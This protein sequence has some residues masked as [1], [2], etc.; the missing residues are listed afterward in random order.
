MARGHIT[1]PTGR[2]HSRRAPSPP[3][4]RLQIGGGPYIRSVFLSRD[5]AGVRA[6]RAEPP[7]G[8]A[9]AAHRPDRVRSVRRRRAAIW[10]GFLRA[11]GSIGIV[12]VPKLSSRQVAAYGSRA[13]ARP[14]ALATARRGTCGQE[15]DL[16]G[17]FLSC[18]ESRA[19]P[20]SGSLCD[21]PDAAA[22]AASLALIWRRSGKTPQRQPVAP[23]RRPWRIYAP[24]R[25]ISAP[26]CAVDAS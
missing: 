15:A 25:R 4:R 10:R 18:R 2:I 20:A 6:L 22:K 21:R 24:P 1:P 19:P 7:A 3:S 14:G 5:T 9:S 8:V 16:H 12:M 23:M 26:S 11:L 13:A 17:M